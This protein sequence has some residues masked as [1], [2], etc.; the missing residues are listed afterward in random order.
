[1]IGLNVDIAGR[2]LLT[3]LVTYEPDKS[4]MIQSLIIIARKYITYSSI[5]ASL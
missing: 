4:V 3:V 1:M 5:T 2:S